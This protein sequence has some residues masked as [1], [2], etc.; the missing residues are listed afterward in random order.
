MTNE[1]FMPRW[2]YV[3]LA[4]IA[5][6]IGL[7]A[8]VITAKFFVL[9]LERIEPDNIARDVLIATGILMIL[10]E[11]LA[12]G[13]AALLPSNQL[14]ALRTKL[15]VCG[16]LL[17]TFEVATIYITQVAL[18]QN[19]AVSATAAETKINGLQKSIENRRAAAQSLRVNG[20][21]QSASTNAWTRTLGAKALREA[22]QAEQQIDPMVA[23]L[24]QLQSQ[25]RPNL[26]NVIGETG[27]LIYSVTRAFLISVMGLVMFGAAGALL[28]ESRPKAVNSSVKVTEKEYSVNEENGVKASSAVN[29]AAAK[30]G[31]V[32]CK[33]S[34]RLAGASLATL[35]FTPLVSA[36]VQPLV[37]VTTDSTQN[38]SSPIVKTA[39]ESTP[40]LAP[41]A[42]KNKK[43]IQNELRREKAEKGRVAKKS[44]TPNQ[45]FAAKD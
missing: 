2:A 24:A 16:A 19:A 1:Q 35:A 20:E 23:E 39:H 4:A 25:V 13:L 33:N 26:A 32:A 34:F 8:S 3:F 12:F 5:A 9:G 15:I 38:V 17:L 30:V 42:P 10:T 14:R 29:S 41:E 6:A 21:S 45:S 27:V 44:K 11:L 40:T 18:M 22:L 31:A 28:R 7:A 36:T 37:P 43:Q